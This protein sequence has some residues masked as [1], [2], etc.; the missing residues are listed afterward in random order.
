MYVDQGKVKLESQTGNITM[1]GRTLGDVA[2]RTHGDV[3][4]GTVQSLKV[5]IRKWLLQVLASY[6]F[7][8]GEKHLLWT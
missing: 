8:S 6:I 1:N 4:T 3:K 7:V 2:C 5:D